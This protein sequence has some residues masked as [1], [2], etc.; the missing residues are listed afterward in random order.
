[1][2]VIDRDGRVADFFIGWDGEAT[3]RQLDTRIASLVAGAP[4]VRR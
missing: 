4:G 3:A 1:M 2:F